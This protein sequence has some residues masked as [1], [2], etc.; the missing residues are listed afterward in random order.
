MEKNVFCIIMAGGS[1]TRF[2]PQ[3]RKAKSKQYLSI[4]DKKSLIQK[5]I[6]RFHSMI[7]WDRIFIVSQKHQEQELN[8][9]ILKIP[10]KN[11]LYEPFGRN[12]APCIGLAA[13]YCQH[14]NPDSV[15][16]V[17]PADHRIANK[18]QFQTVMQTA[19]QLANTYNSVVTMGITPDRPATGYG[20]IQ[21]DGVVEATKKV[22]SFKV[23]TFA[24]KPNLATA[25]RFLESGDFFWNS[26]IFIFKTSVILEK[27]KEHLPDLHESLSEIKNFMDDSKLDKVIH[28]V[29]QQIK[30]VSIDY[31]IME[32]LND[33]CMV[34]GKFG[35]NDLGSWEQVYKLSET[36]ENNNYSNGN[37]ILLN[38]RNSYIRTDDNGLI[39]VIGVDDVAV[40]K[41]GDAVLVCKMDEAEKVKKVVERLKTKKLDQYL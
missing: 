18:S 26:G 10:S 8:K 15:M 25:Q 29:Y 12:T 4:L 7:S 13:L 23:K 1:G 40:V 21:V 16:I 34:E 11:L 38:T 41:E 35:W 37:T 24:E 5:T 14:R 28:K 30:D 39:A 20:Y 3:S 36:D 22:K 32:K 6:E 9:H 2:W 17:S 31:G 19:V 33:V 27:I